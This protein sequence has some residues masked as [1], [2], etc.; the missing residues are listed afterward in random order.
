MLFIVCV[1]MHQNDLPLSWSSVWLTNKSTRET[2][3]KRINNA[4]VDWSS[5]KLSQILKMFSMITQKWVNLTCVNKILELEF[6]SVRES[7]DS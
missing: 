2:Q 5:F 1:N 6:A 7:F 3:I 4:P